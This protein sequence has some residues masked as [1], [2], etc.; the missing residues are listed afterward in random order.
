MKLRLV[1]KQITNKGK[2]VT[3]K[4]NIAPSQQIGFVNF[5]NLALNQDNNVKIS[6]EKI[7]KTGDKEES[8]IAGL[9][10]FQA[11]GKEEIIQLEEEVKEEA[12][13]RQKLKSK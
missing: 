7:S 12:K 4:F 2:D 11:K 8:K 13:K 9:F 6:F 10:K 5:V 3:I 1:L